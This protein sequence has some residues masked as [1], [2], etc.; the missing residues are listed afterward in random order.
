MIDLVKDI[1]LVTD[2]YLDAIGIEP[3]DRSDFRTALAH[4][5]GLDNYEPARVNV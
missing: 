1:D 5:L 4:V 3:E 2:D